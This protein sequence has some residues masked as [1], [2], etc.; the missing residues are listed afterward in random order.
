MPSGEGVPARRLILGLFL[1]MSAATAVSL[2]AF[3]HTTDGW[4]FRATVYR[5][6]A[7]D[8]GLPVVVWFLLS[9]IA[10]SRGRR[11]FWYAGAL[12]AGLIAVALV[13]LALAATGAA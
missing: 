10:A 1:A 6:L 11:W 4:P 12:P 9:G 8:L 5:A 2:W 13:L 7:G 3:A